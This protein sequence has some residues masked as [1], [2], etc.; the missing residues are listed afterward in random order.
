M[1]ERTVRGWVG[2]AGGPHRPLCTEAVGGDCLSPPTPPLLR[3][4]PSHL[5]AS[6]ASVPHP[7]VLEAGSCKWGCLC[8][9]CL[10]CLSLCVCLPV[11]SFSCLPPAVSK[12]GVTPSPGGQT[13][14]PMN[15]EKGGYLWCS[16][17]EQIPPPTTIT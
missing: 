16:L 1:D 11:Y 2:G 14:D 7:L 9:V 15:Q 10:P 3:A 17:T 8:P 13:E 5:S 12:G 4:C 6:L